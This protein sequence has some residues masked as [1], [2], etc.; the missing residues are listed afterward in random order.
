M[1][2]PMRFVRQ[3]NEIDC[4]IAVAAMVAGCSWT[5][6]VNADENNEA[7]EGLSVNELA[8]LC[9]AL[10]SPVTIKKVSRPLAL[11][12]ATPPLG[13]RAVLI[14]RKG[15]A[16]GHFVALDGTTVLDPELGRHSMAKYTRK[17]WLVLRWYVRS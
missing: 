15:T 17:H 4:G 8:T 16:R 7:T 9:G 2:E 13:T 1:E 11:K 6:A 5:K 14:R 12:D 3:Y 10:G